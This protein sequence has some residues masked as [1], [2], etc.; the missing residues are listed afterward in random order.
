MR[1]L[2]RHAS[3]IKSSSIKSA[4]KELFILILGILAACQFRV[5][6]LFEQVIKHVIFSTYALP[7]FISSM[8][9]SF[10]VMK[11]KL[12]AVGISYFLELRLITNSSGTNFIQDSSLRSF[13]YIYYN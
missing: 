1:L 4:M 5:I 7:D 8:T 9:S 3:S 12:A 2:V 10:C 6:I 13:L 11:L